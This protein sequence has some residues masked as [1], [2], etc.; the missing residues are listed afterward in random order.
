MN[1]E[2]FKLGW[3]ERVGDA[4]H[5]LVALG[6]SGAPVVNEDDVVVGFVSWRDLINADRKMSVSTLMSSPAAVVDADEDITT[7]VSILCERNIHHLVCIDEQGHAVG[8]V[9][10]LDVLRGVTGRPVPHPDAFPHW[11]PETGLSWSND[12]RFDRAAVAELKPKMPGLFALIAPGKAQP[13]RVVWV[14]AVVDVAEHLARMFDEPRQAP[15]HLA[16]AIHRGELWFRVALAPSARGL[17]E[18]ISSAK[19]SSRRKSASST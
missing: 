12:A 9:G 14:E 11:D 19:S 5:Y 8:F 17:M 1:R 7:A 2:L 16:D 18:A 10:S 3:N 6:I 4:L 15:P 13:D